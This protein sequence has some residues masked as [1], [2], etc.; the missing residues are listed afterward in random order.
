[1]LSQMRALL[2]LLTGLLL[3]ESAPA[4]PLSSYVQDACPDDCFA[5]AED[6]RVVSIVASRADDPVV[7][8][9][10]EDLAADLERV[11]GRRPVVHYD[12]WPAEPS[13]VVGS[14]AHS[15]LIR[16][17]VETGRLEPGEIEGRWEAF[18]LQVVSDVRGADRL[19]I[20][21]SDP[22][23]TVFGIYDLSR[24]MGVSPWYW[25]ADV[26]VPHRP[27]LYVARTLR[28]TDYPRVRY[29]GLFINDE[30]P[31]LSGWAFEKF[32]GFNHRFYARVFELILRLKGNFLWPAMWGR[33]FFEED[34]LNIPTAARYGIVIGTSHHEPM[35]R[36]HVEWQWHGGGPW[37]YT[38]NAATLQAFWREGIRR[39][40]HNEAIVTVGMRG[41]GDEPMSEETAIELLER[42]IRDQRRILAEETGRDPS[43]IP[44]AWTIYKEV[45]DYYEKGMRVPEDITIVFTDDNWGNV[46]LLPPPGSPPRKGGYGMYYHFDYVG[47]PRSYKWINTVQIERTW[48]QMRLTYRHGVDRLWVVNVGDIKPMELPL[49]FFMDMAWDPERFTAADLP[50]YYERWAAEQFGPRYAAEIATLL[51]TYTKYNAR[52]KPELLDADTYS[53]HHY[54]E[55]DRVVADYRALAARA[56]ALHERMP[57]AYRDAFYQLV[58]YPVMAS[59]NLYEMYHALALNRLYARQ[60]RAATNRMA[61][62][63]RRLFA[64]DA[65]LAA[66]YNHVMGAGRWNHMMDQPRI[67]Y[68]SWDDPDENIMPEVETIAVPD[69]ALPAVAVEGQPEAWPGPDAPATLPVFDDLTRPVHYLEVFNRGRQPFRFRIQAEAPAL[70]FSATE[71]EVTEQQRIQVT[72]DWAQVP[73]GAEQLVFYVEGPGMR[74]PVVVPLERIV[75]RMPP[76]FEGFVARDGHL[77]IEAH[78]FS[79]QVPVGEAR[80]EVIPN[81]GRTASAVTP[82][83]VTMRAQAPGTDN[84]RLEY[85]VL[86]PTPGRIRVHLYLSPTYNFVNRPGGLRLAVSL[87]DA[88]PQLLEVHAADTIPDWRYGH[89]WMDAVAR[90]VRIVTSAHEITRPGPHTLKLWAVDGGVVVERIVIDTGGL[91]PSY[92]GPPESPFVRDRRT[93]WPPEPEA[94]PAHA[95]GDTR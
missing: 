67:G 90:N 19:V 7:L 93:H 10:V 95:A 26:P 76:D 32:G 61:E 15:P 36:A 63:V 18:L 53:L 45:Q 24:A 71:G 47:A 59:A 78:H 68:T 46:R 2:L 8:R 23:G 58:A 73:P 80:W 64:R 56:Q 37:D 89:V 31:A 66:Y 85:D 4:Q 49:T 72:V 70:A 55:F 22:R 77:A 28:R 9:A 14:L 50:R 25:W 17:L 82:L 5:L 29:R 84:P 13:L 54:R 86:L 87:D 81:L 92:L 21:G 60:R 69:T 65:E 39:M 57:A 1:M 75:D 88:P 42:I 3:I 94:G 11:T 83:P 43:E 20:A 48:E 30:A 41:D 6:G 12:T 27:A 38:K 34:S 44:Q 35:L 74:V 16:E 33:S 40:K 91:R 51:A 62:K 52:R 79:R